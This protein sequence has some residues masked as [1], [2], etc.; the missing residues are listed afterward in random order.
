M[1][2]NSGEGLHAQLFPLMWSI[3][4]PYHLQFVEQDTKFFATYIETTSFS[5]IVHFFFFFFFT[6]LHGMQNLSSPTGD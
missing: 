3:K 1:F 2:P 4:S 5:I 6:T